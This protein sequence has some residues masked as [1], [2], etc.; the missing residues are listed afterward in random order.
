[1]TLDLPRG[2]AR[3]GRG[4]EGRG[5]VS[6]LKHEFFCRPVPVRIGRQEADKG[7]KV[8]GDTDFQSMASA[9][10]TTATTGINK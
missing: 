7:K 9:L 4:R 10:M 1:M 6:S 8:P 2:E 5:T 3:E